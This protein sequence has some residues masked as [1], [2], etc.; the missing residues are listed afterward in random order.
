MNDKNIT[1]GLSYFGSVAYFDVDLNNESKLAD[2][3]H[4]TKVKN[5]I[6]YQVKKTWNKNI[7]SINIFLKLTLNYKISP[8]E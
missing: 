4:N 5:I 1:E 6:E 7:K 3:E 8:Q 2:V